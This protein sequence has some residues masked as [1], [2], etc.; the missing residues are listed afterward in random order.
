MELFF[1]QIN[2]LI[3]GLD[4]FFRATIVCMF[5]VLGIWCFAKVVKL[6]VNAAKF[7][8]KIFPIIFALLFLTIA[9]YVALV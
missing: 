5:A 7:K 4:P 2:D 9:G 3:I 8:I 1:S 6:H